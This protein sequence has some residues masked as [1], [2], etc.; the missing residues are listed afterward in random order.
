MYEQIRSIVETIKRN[1]P[2]IL[3]VT[4]LVT[5]DFVANGLL[6]LGASPIMINGKHEIR[7]LVKIAKGVVIN[8][9]TLDDHFVSLC[10][11][12]CKVANELSIPIVLDPVGA[13]ASQYR[14][15][16]CLNLL[17]KYQFAI[18]R[19]NAS[20][21]MALC[22]VNHITKGVDSNVLTTEVIEPAKELARQ[23]QATITMSGETDFILSCNQVHR[24]E[25]G[26]PYMPMVTGSG[27][28]LTAIIS[29]FHAIE[30]EAY[31]AAYK[32]TNFYGACGEQAM[33]KASGPGSF[34][35][36]FLDALSTLPKR[37]DYEAA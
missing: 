2:L 36:L 18:I 8:I 33:S 5:M 9:G 7:D 37:D 15:K 27:C 13:G 17:E 4:N 12:V 26:V 25:R 10:E 31:S 14:T 1:R 32:A 6:S 22:G 30:P 11:G 28:L 16:T 23:L 29:A 24:C 19:G 35:P 34:K 21:V 3:N 20:E